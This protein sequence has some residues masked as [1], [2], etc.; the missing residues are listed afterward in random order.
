MEK[1]VRINNKSGIHVRPAAQIAEMANKFQASIAFVKDGVEI[2]AK[3]IMEL[4]TL[5]AG[6]GTNIIIK[7]NGPDE[8]QAV[9]ALESLINTKFYEE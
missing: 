9:E 8:L 4:L 3:S 7:A 6:E 5:A 2:N 1:L